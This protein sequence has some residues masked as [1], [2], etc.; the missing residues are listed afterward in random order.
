[1]FFWF[2][3]MISFY[4]GN[5]QKKIYFKKITKYNQDHDLILSNVPEYS[6]IKKFF[7][8]SFWTYRV[9]RSSLK[10]TAN[11]ATGKQ[12]WIGQPRY[13]VE[14]AA[15]VPWWKIVCKQKIEEFFFKL[16]VLRV[17]GEQKTPHLC[18][19][20]C[21]WI[22]AAGINRQDNLSHWGWRSPQTSVWKSAFLKGGDI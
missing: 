8:L 22:L 21:H 1:M 7:P 17:V 20:D 9:T 4:C 19:C 14:R 16:E 6:Y 12:D 10:R 18:L 11:R 2:C 5:S 15:H 13:S 3:Y